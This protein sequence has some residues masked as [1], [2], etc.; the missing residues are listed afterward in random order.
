MR[1]ANR[2]RT[3][4]WPGELPTIPASNRVPPEP[5]Q[6]G[7][8]GR[9][10]PRRHGCRYLGGSTREAWVSARWTDGGDDA[11]IDVVLRRRIV[12]AVF[13]PVLQLDGGLPAGYC[14]SVRGPLGSA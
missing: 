3:L 4:R 6:Y 11:R 8:S 1:R 14:G 13:E 2:R 10:T 9:T 5:A 7:L 12:R